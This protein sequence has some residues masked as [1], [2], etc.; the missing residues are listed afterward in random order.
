MSM[1][2]DSTGEMTALASPFFSYIYVLD[3]SHL[4]SPLCVGFYFLQWNSQFDPSRKWD[5]RDEL[6]AT[7]N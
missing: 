4:L 2:N 7:Q 1:S 3:V 6:A 5:E